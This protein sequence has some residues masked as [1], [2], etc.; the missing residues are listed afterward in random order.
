MWPQILF[1]IFYSA[2]YFRNFMSK[3]FSNVSFKVY[4]FFYFRIILQISAYE[5]YISTKI[6]YGSFVFEHNCT[7]KFVMIFFYMFCI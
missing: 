6:L 2:L 5:F 4:S 3:Y 7:S 1:L